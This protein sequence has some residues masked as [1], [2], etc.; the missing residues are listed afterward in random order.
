M[1]DKC[2]NCGRDMTFSNKALFGKDKNRFC[3]FCLLDM[4]TKD[5][6]EKQEIINK[7][8]D[9][10]NNVDD[11]NIEC[12]KNATII[13]VNNKRLDKMRDFFNNEIFDDEKVLFLINGEAKNNSFMT[14]GVDKIIGGGDDL[15]VTNERVL[16]SKRGAKKIFS[17]STGE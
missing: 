17:G 1:V 4:A 2:E 3:R 14:L 6:K 12:L 15:L 11:L 10:L 5:Y 16:I 9:R 7:S 13:G 8:Q